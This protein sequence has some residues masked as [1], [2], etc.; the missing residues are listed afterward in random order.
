MMGSLWQFGA[1]NALYGA[2]VTA[3]SSSDAGFEATNLLNPFPWSKW[4]EDASTGFVNFD[5]GAA[6]AVDY[7]AIEVPNWPT[8]TGTI[9]VKGSN[10]PTFVSG[11]VTLATFSYVAPAAPYFKP[12]P[13]SLWKSFTPGSYRYFRVETNAVNAYLAVLSIGNAYVPVIGEFVGLSVPKYAEDKDIINT[14]S[15]SGY[16]LGRTVIDRGVSFDVNLE[17][18]TPAWVEDIGMRLIHILQE[19]PIFVCWPKYD[20]G[21]GGRCFHC[22]TNGEIGKPTNQTVQFMNVGFK[23]RGV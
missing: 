18:L 7:A 4:F 16:Y 19:K 22:W 17:Y 14:I 20:A 11:T 10:D 13:R 6:V 15:E 8:Y 12:A 21:Q 5:C 1:E 2:T 9:V 23:L 3:S